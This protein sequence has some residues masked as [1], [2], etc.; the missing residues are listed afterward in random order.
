MGALKRFQEKWM[1]IFRRK[2]DKIKNIDALQRLPNGLVLKDVTVTY[3]RVPAV[4]HLSGIFK[5]ASMTAIA[6]PNGAGKSTLL[7]AIMG[8]VP[9]SEG[10][11]DRDGQ[12]PADIAYLPQVNEIDRSFPIPVG[13]LVGLGWW[14]A[15]G[16]FAGLTPV[17]RHGVGDALRLV[18]L[19]RL[20]QSPIGRMSAGQFQRALFARLI[21]RDASLVLLDEPFAGV[22]ERTTHDLIELIK[23]WVSQGRTII[24]VL[25]DLDLIEREFPQTLLL[26]RE[27]VAWG[28]TQDVLTQS[29]LFKARQITD[30]WTA[31]IARRQERHGHEH[32]ASTQSGAAP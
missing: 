24:A 12:K 20:A 31:E 25:H 5:P 26:A 15:A 28:P 27:C 17:Q 23:T 10:S 1:P 32:G 8:F 9:L 21:L 6:G 19:E 7:R 18:G 30:K 16:S 14:R 2:R 4:H 29:N 11:I 3:N 22:D 13:D